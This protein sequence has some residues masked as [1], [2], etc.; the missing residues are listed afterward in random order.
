MAMTAATSVAERWVDD[1]SR[2]CNQDKELDDHGKFFSCSYMLD[3]GERTFQVIMNQGKV[4]DIR[5]DPGPLD[6]RYQFLLRAS[7]DTWREFGPLRRD[8]FR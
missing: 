7:A 2:V 8:H 6:V 4:A 1:F 5:I 3:M